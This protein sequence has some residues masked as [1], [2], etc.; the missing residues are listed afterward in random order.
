MPA[1]ARS[2]PLLLLCVAATIT[3]GLATRRAPSRFPDVV[4]TYGGDVLW[5]T[6]VYW[7]VAFARPAASWRVLAAITLF[8]AFGV[9]ASQLAHTPWL[10]ALRAT[11]L[12]ALVLGRGFLVSDLVAYCVG[13]VLALL[14]DRAMWRL[15]GTGRSR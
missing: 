1:L 15:P 9:E 13:T 2:R 11:R 10:D 5:A 7:L 8:I 6:M 12:G 14:L 4:A 3:L